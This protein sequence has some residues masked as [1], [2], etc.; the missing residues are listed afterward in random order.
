MNTA[1]KLKKIMI[2]ENLSQS[3]LAKIAGVSEGAVTG[4]MNGA[5]PR[6]RALA[7][8]SDKLE[9][10]FY[11]LEDPDRELKKLSLKEAIR[12]AMAGL[13]K[14]IK[15]SPPFEYAAFNE[16]TAFDSVEMLYGVSL[17][18]NFRSLVRIILRYGQLDYIKAVEHAKSINNMPLAMLLLLLN[19]I[20]VPE[21]QRRFQSKE[22]KD[23]TGK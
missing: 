14:Q 15:E 6:K 11:S 10:D 13:E 8:I 18:E 19:K 21:S 16:E 7:K 23:E 4:W 5:K 17:D 3:D 9:Y 12:E 22:T 1:D 20:Q 2:N